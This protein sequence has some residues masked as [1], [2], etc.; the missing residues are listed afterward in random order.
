MN[1]FCVFVFLC[2][3]AVWG[4]NNPLKAE[5]I[6]LN[7][8]WQFQ[9]LSANSGHAELHNQGSDWQ[10]QFNVVH[11]E[12]SSVLQVPADSLER[13]FGLLKRG[14][15]ETVRL[16]HTPFVEDL[17]VLHQWQGVCYYKRKLEGR[18]EWKDKT[19]WLEFGGAMSLADIWVNGKHM[20]QHAGGYLPVVI[21]LSGKLDLEGENEILVRLDNRDNGLFPPGKPLSTL[22]FCTMA[23]YTGTY[24]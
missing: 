11:V 2:I 24:V 10:S 4:G 17:V 1:R 5:I 15:W 6:G 20:M 12:S 7:G 18:A 22:D 23:G 19:L 8:G 14:Q 3:L 21:D 16:P 13:E 9:R